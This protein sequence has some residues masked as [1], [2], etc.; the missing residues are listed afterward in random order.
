MSSLILS[1]YYNMSVR[2]SFV[3]KFLKKL[4]TSR[5][6]YGIFLFQ[7]EVTLM[8]KLT[9]KQSKILEFIRN[10]QSKYSTSPALR[11]IMGHFKFKAIATVQ[12]H[13]SALERKG[14][15][16]REKDK[17]RSIS[18]L[19]LKKTLRDIIEVPVLGR[20]AAG[21]P[22]LAVENIEG[23]VAIDKTW[24]KGENIFALRVQGNSMIN[25]GIYEGDFVIVKQQPTAENGEIVVALIEDEATVKRFYK[26]EDTITLKAENPN[27][28]P[29]AYHP[30]DVT[31]SIIGKVIGAF[32]KY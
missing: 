17:A 23:F 2:S 28:E 9:E 3:T 18:I 22:I 15:I 20:V 12:D 32:R 16:K 29:F 7:K 25:A 1:L 26:T 31:V 21:S 11:E 24:V 10:F 19:G 30:E 14:C 13:L 4:L 5:Q 8:E 6:M 27:I